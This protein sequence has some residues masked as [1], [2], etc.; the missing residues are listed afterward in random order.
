MKLSA[1]K[2]WKWF[3]L[4][5]TVA[6]FTQIV[7]AG[8]M[9]MGF[10]YFHTTF[11]HLIFFPILIALILAWRQK[12]GRLATRLIGIIFVVVLIQAEPL[13]HFARLAGLVLATNNLALLAHGINALILY[14]LSLSV[15]VWAVRQPEVKQTSSIQS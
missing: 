5:S 2:L 4:I 7:L 6:I 13:A 15:T 8:L 10:T 14:T 11:G 3:L 12:A 1:M 9:F